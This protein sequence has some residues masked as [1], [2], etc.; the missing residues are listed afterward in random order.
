MLVFFIV[1]TAHIFVI[2]I[3][4]LKQF[5]ILLFIFFFNQVIKGRYE[6]KGDKHETDEFLKPIIVDPEGRI[7][8]LCYSITVT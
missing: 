5:E 4:L 6:A 8:G 1:L 2:N 3:A 7:K